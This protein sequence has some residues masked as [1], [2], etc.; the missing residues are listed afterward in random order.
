[1]CIRDSQS[2]ADAGQLRLDTLYVADST[3]SVL[4]RVLGLEVGERSEVVLDRAGR[5]LYVLDAIEAPRRKTFD[6]AR[7][8]LITDY[9]EVVEEAWEARLRERYDAETYPSRVTPTSS[10]A[11]PEGSGP[12]AVVS[13]S[14]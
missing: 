4:D 3:D 5:V 14:P 8:Q 9:Q 6:E 11:P 7:A 12:A 13:E 10:V 1:M 2:L